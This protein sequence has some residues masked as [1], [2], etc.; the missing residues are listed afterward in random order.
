MVVGINPGE[1]ILA[2]PS[3]LFHVVLIKFKEEATERQR[4][5]IYN[6]YQTLGEDCGGKDAG[7]LYWAVQ[8][9]LDQ[10]KGW[11][12]VE[13]AIF[14]GDDVLQAFRIHPNHSRVTDLLREIADWV[15]GDCEV[16][17]PTF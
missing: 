15:V 6:W 17:P 11:N 4:Q 8:P 7:I 5:Q 10:R 12:L 9:N 1:T 2:S 3:V 14:T 16:T 13:L